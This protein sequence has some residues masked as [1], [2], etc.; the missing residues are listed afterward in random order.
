MKRLLG[1]VLL[2]AIISSCSLAFAAESQTSA[3]ELIIDWAV[4]ANDYGNGNVEFTADITTL[5]SVDKLGFTSLKL[6]EKQGSK[7]VTV[8]SA[9]DKYAYGIAVYSYSLSYGGT[10]GNQYRFVVKY[11]AKDGDIVETRS[12]T[13]SVLTAKHS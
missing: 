5:G 2:V 7:W 8:K 10:P 3:S 4:Y 13:S 6:Q 1:L 11:Y 12:T 9:T